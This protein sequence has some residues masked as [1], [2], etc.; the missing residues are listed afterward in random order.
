MLTKSLSPII[1]FLL[2][3]CGMTGTPVPGSRSIPSIGEIKDTLDPQTKPPDNNQGVGSPSNKQGGTLSLASNYYFLGNGH[4]PK[5]GGF[6]GGYWKAGKWMTLPRVN[7]Q[8]FAFASAIFISGADVFVGATVIDRAQ[9]SRRSISYLRNDTWNTV[10]TPD[11]GSDLNISSLFVSGSDTHI[12]GSYLKSSTRVA[13]YW[14]NSNIVSLPIINSARASSAIK[15][16][17]SGSDVYIS[18]NQYD[19]SKVPISVAGYWKNNQWT[20]LTSNYRDRDSLANCTAGAIAISGADIFVPGNC[21]TGNVNVGLTYYLGFWKNGVWTELK[22]L[23]SQK[24]GALNY[25]TFDNSDIYVG[26]FLYDSNRVKKAGYWKNGT[27]IALNPPNPAKDSEVNFIS[28][29]GGNVVAAGNAYKNVPDDVRSA[30]GHWENGQ[31]VPAQL[32]E[33]LKSMRLFHGAK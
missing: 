9:T 14:K 6:V 25:I 10:A 19:N 12:V 26:G 4:D 22:S 18:G 15:V 17:V 33:G 16:I 31:W 27:W 7:E 11:V 24:G 29:V 3:S 13:G 8:S 5:A 30:P 20:S 2:S 23:D 32:P 21:Y 1:L 28:V